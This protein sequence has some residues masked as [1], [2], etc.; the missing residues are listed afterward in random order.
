VGCLK[1]NNSFPAESRFSSRGSSLYKLQKSAQGIDLAIDPEE[2][3]PCRGRWGTGERV[4]PQTHDCGVADDDLRSPR[5]K[6]TMR[7]IVKVQGIDD[8][9]RRHLHPWHFQPG[10]L[11]NKRSAVQ[12]C[13][14]PPGGCFPEERRDDVANS[15][16]PR[17]G[18]FPSLHSGTTSQE[19]PRL[20][21]TVPSYILERMC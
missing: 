18:C 14:R 13:G 1:R 21:L 3:F 12:V 6:T 16:L 15:G 20:S 4:A 5:L 7:S 10:Q 2:Q 8:S 17:K 9:H 19:P 11:C